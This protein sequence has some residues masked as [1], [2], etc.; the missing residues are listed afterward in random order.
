M[1][2]DLLPLILALIV[3][4]IVYV[5]RE[6]RRRHSRVNP[7]L[8][9][10]SMKEAFDLWLRGLRDDPDRQFVPAEMVSGELSVKLLA[11]AEASLLE[12]ER[13][14][15]E[16]DNPRLAVRRAIL[17]SAAIGLHLE[18]IA[19][20]GETERKALLKGYVEGMDGLLRHAWRLSVLRWIALRHYARF[21][22]DDAVAGDWF[23]HFMQVARPYVREKVRLGRES[24]L[25]LDEG[26]GQFAQIYDQLLE[27]LQQRMLKVRPKK[28]FV[29]VDLP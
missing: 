25:R 2:R 5:L 13:H 3:A 6:I 14:F 9:R 19:E 7:P 29:P 18:A 21:K 20:F 1:L 8:P 16:A 27:E 23:H 4:Y 26:S 11:D 24:V 17:E 12:T 22:H 15:L 10:L 28:R